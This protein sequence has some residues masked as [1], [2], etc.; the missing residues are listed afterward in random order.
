VA[1]NSGALL[2]RDDATVLGEIFP[3]L[4]QLR[5]QE[6]LKALAAKSAIGHSV[7]LGDLSAL[8]RRNLKEI[9][10]AIKK[11]QHA[12]GVAWQLDRLG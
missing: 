10:V 5:L 3:F 4:F 7:Q 6:Q 9:F 1:K 8:A 11:I 12:I 2:R